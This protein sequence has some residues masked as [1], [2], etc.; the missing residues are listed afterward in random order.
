MQIEQCSIC[1]KPKTHSIQYLPKCKHTFHINCIQ[2]WFRRNPGK[3]CPLCRGSNLNEP[4]IEDNTYVVELQ[5]PKART[6][7]QRERHEDGEEG[8]D[9][10]IRERHRRIKNDMPSW[11][12]TNPRA[13]HAHDLYYAMCSYNW[14]LKNEGFTWIYAVCDLMLIGFISYVLTLTYEDNRTPCDNPERHVKEC[15]NVRAFVVCVLVALIVDLIFVVA[16]RKYSVEKYRGRHCY[17]SF[18]VMVMLAFTIG[19]IM[20]GVGETSVGTCDGSETNCRAIL[21][22]DNPLYGVCVLIPPINMALLIIIH[23][24]FSYRPGMDEPTKKRSNDL[25]DALGYDP[26]WYPRF[27]VSN[28][29]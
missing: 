11:H 5:R 8:Q 28:R 29:I 4:E 18:Q 7:S 21:W 10:K 20:L 22:G 25:L 14:A 19:S 17:R 27:E 15:F 3:E 1:L 24:A 16:F 9:R 2:G 26:K 12:P 13:N 23:L 6:E